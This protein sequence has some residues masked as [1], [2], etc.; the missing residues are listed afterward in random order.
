MNNLESIQKKFRKEQDHTTG[1]YITYAMM[2]IIN[3][4]HDIHQQNRSQNKSII[5][6]DIFA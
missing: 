6:Q 3:L 1:T 2:S 4:Q 5:T